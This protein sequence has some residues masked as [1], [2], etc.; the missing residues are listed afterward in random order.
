[1]IACRPDNRVEKKEERY[2]STSMAYNQGILV[3]MK[4]YMTIPPCSTIK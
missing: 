3:T 4:N 1:M 2:K